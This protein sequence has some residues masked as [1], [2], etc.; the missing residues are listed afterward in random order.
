MSRSFSNPVTREARRTIT[1]LSER[2]LSEIAC[3]TLAGDPQE[4]E[5]GN[6]VSFTHCARTTR[7]LHVYT[8]CEYG[9]LFSF[10]LTNSHLT[11]VRVIQQTVEGLRADDTEARLLGPRVNP[12][13]WSL[14]MGNAEYAL[15]TQVLS[16][17][18]Y[19]LKAHENAL[20]PLSLIYC[21]RDEA[22]RE[23]THE[24]DLKK[25][26][27]ELEGATVVQA[28]RKIM[29]DRPDVSI[30]IYFLRDPLTYSYNAERVRLI[31]TGKT[32]DQ[33][34]VREPCIG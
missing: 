24:V 30:E 13:L 4:R 27:P 17:S 34:H 15:G 32:G 3:R 23:R 6:L 33:F 21:D 7:A 9:L 2:Q 1:R 19:T 20:P 22:R 14:L 26:W 11:G 12:L 16:F 31:V 28:T 8:G 10:Y 18:G 29:F 5:A 25:R